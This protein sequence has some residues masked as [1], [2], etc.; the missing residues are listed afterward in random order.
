MT[1]FILVCN[2]PQNTHKHQ[3]WLNTMY[4]WTSVW[5]RMPCW[6]L[7]SSRICSFFLLS[8]A[9]HL[10]ASLY[11]ALIFYYLSAFSTVLGD[12]SALPLWTDSECTFLVP[13]TCVCDLLLA[14]NKIILFYLIILSYLIRNTVNMEPL[15]HRLK[16]HLPFFVFICMHLIISRLQIKVRA[17]AWLHM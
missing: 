7:P 14:I 11:S 15:S 4:T 8:L 6:K 12:A 3:S 5:W 16:Q 17:G 2:K 9:R 1:W 13:L 10:E